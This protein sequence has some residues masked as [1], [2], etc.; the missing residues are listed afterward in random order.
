M[1]P[2][3][4]ASDDKF[5]GIIRFTTESGRTFVAYGDPEKHA[6]TVKDMIE[7]MVK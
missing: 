4:H 7:E 2:N 3:H 1:T 6:E 5:P